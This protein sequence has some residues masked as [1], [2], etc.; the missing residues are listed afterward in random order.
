MF[1]FFNHYLK[2]TPAPEWM[3]KGIPAIE[4]GKTLGY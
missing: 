4:K 2:G 3:I 1:G